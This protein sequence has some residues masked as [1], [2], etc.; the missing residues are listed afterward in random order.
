MTVDGSDTAWPQG[1]SGG[2]GSFN[3]S[4]A[5]RGNVGLQVDAGY[6]ARVASTR[7][8]GA[9][10]GHYHFNGNQPPVQQADFFVD[11]L[12][13]F[14]TGDLLALDS[15]Y[16]TRTGTQAMNPPNAAAFFDRVHARTGYPYQGM[17][18]YINRSIR[19]QW[20]WSGVWGRG[21]RKWI[22]SPGTDPGDWDLWQYSESGGIDHDYSRTPLAQFIGGN[23]PLDATADYAAFLY[24]LQR[25]LHFDLRKN[26]SGT[27]GQTWQAGPTIYEQLDTIQSLLSAAGVTL[28]DDQ[29]TKLADQIT[30]K[31]PAS[32]AASKQDV[33]DALKTLTFKA[34]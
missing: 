16:E 29:I 5:T 24:M 9:E 27:P 19:S 33:I 4:C 30:A 26:S 3:I 17:A 20:D 18:C 32:Q 6:S 22:A 21:V 11:H 2:V 31:L 12:V 14:R 25:A 10:V 15:E 7:A 8:R 28:T 13:D 23:M 1:T 34:E